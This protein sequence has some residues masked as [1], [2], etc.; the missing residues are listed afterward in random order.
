VVLAFFCLTLSFGFSILFSGL[1]AAIP[2]VVEEK[3]MGTAYGVLGCVIGL[4]QIFMPFVNTLI[5]DSDPDL[6]V[7]YKTLN[8]TYTIMAALV[9]TLALVMKHP[10]FDSLDITF[11]QTKEK[12]DS[13]AK[14]D[15]ELAK[16]EDAPI[17][18][19]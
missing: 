10:A 6:A 1:M 7:S 14:A 2:Y 17:A 16:E 8:L 5:I 18:T 4:S 15:D 19:S 9:L 13:K 11:K 12:E 3:A